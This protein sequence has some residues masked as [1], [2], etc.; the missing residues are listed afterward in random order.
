MGPFQ[1]GAQSSCHHCRKKATCAPPFNQG[2]GGIRLDFSGITD[3][4]ESIEGG[5]EACLGRAH[6]CPDTY[7]DD[8]RYTAKW[9]QGQLRDTRGLPPLARTALIPRCRSRCQTLAIKGPNYSTS[10]H[11][12]EARQNQLV[13]QCNECSGVYTLGWSGGRHGDT[14][15]PCGTLNQ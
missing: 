6:L 15:P 4:G 11:H 5:D 10:F 14:V 1:R 9:K 2:E 8:H 12:S 7:C 3:F 13:K